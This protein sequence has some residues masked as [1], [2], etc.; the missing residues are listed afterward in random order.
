MERNLQQPTCQVASFRWSGPCEIGQA[1]LIV[2]PN[3]NSQVNGKADGGMNT[4]CPC[5][6]AMSSEASVC[7]LH[8]LGDFGVRRLDAAFICGG[9]TPLSKTASSLSERRLLQP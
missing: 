1:S 3:P 7:K 4:L 5:A 2:R 9:L 8:P 6:E